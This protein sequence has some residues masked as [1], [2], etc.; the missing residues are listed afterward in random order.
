MLR[1]T[2]TSVSPAAT[3]AVIEMAMSSRLTKRPL[4]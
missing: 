2:I 1:V 4:R 3:S